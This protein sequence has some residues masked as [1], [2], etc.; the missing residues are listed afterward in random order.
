MAVYKIFPSQDTTLYSA[1]PNMNTGIDALLEVSS[2]VPSEAPSPRVARAIVKFDQSEINNVVDNIIGNLNTFS[3]SFQA[4]VATADGVNF[5][6]TMEIYPVSGSWFNGN[7]MY[8]DTLQNTRGCSWKWTDFS[9]SNQWPIAGYGPLLTGSYSGSSNAGGGV[10]YTGSG[11]YAGIG[12]L[13][14][15]QSFTVRGDKDINVN[16]TDALKVWYSSSKDINQGLINIENNGFLLKWD[17]SIE[18]NP[19]LAVQ[20]AYTFYSV[21][22]NTIYPPQ[23]EFKWN[24]FIYETGSLSVI[25]TPDLFVAVDENEGVY[26]SESINNFR[27]NVRPKYPIRTFQTES[28]YT[29]NFALPT[30]SYYA[31]KDLDTNEYVVDFDVDYTKISCDASGSYFKVYMN[32]LQPERYYKILIQTTVNGNTIVIDDENYFKVTNG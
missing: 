11:G 18:F 1:Y 10:W 2:T 5:D 26:Y 23:L 22:T 8:L 4:F 19:S 29:D 17:D 7:G 21:D 13:E 28:V 32:G 15:S 9:G 12:N 3:S 20:P 14:F 27:L 24:D 16:V 6:S 25:N 30:S 31:I